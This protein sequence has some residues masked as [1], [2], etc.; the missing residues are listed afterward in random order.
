KLLRALPF[1]VVKCRPIE[2]AIITAGGVNVKEIDPK[3]MGSKKIHGLFFAG[4][5]ID[6]DGVTGGFNIQAA[7]STGYRSGLG[8]ANYLTEM[9]E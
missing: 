6:I 3:T 5:V 4:E 2:E 7:L 8:A 1:T 9:D